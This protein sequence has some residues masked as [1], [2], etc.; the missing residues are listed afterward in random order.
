MKH[1]IGIDL[2]TTNSV[3]ATFDGQDP[4]IWKSPEQ[5]DITPSAIFIDR[6][7]RRYIGQ[8][9]YDAAPRDPENSALLF[10]RLMGTST[11]IRLAAAGL[12]LTPQEC[13]AEILKA[14]CGYLDEEILPQDRTAAVITVPAAFN[15]MQKNATQKAASLAGIGQAALIQEPVAAVMSVMRSD[16]PEGLFLIYDLGGGTLDIALAEA[17]GGRVNLLA[18]GGL[19]LF[20]GRDFDRILVHSLVRPWLMNNFSLPDDLPASPRYRSLMRLAAWA[21]EKAKTE[22]S[23]REETVISLSENETRTADLDGAEIFLDIPLSRTAF[24][25]LMARQIT[26]SVEAARETLEKAGLSPGDLE[27]IVFIGG[28]TKYKPLRDKVAFELGIRSAAQV[29]PLTAVAEGASIYA[30]S[31]DWTT[32]GRSRKKGP[33]RLASQ[34]SLPLIF[35]YP[36]RTPE[37]RAVISLQADNPPSGAEFQVDSLDTG[38]TS[39]RLPLTGGASVRVNLAKPGENTFKVFAFQASGQAL[40]L[41][42]DRLVITRTAAAVESIPASHSLGIEVLEKHGGRPA[43]AFLVRSGESLPKKGVQIFRAAETLRAGE[44]K[45]LNF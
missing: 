11:P 22:L 41:N 9:A 1:F 30:E 20:G 33:G 14:L 43:L 36:S 16:R 27:R 4:R 17:L 26:E 23:V 39:G 31:I 12:T 25:N 10:K 28:P 19:A 44:A 40:P 37:A 24:D 45:S 15:Q 32:P 13:S 6:R 3:I 34:G 29:N 18:H 42:E 21:A 8:R 38:W 7:G 2:G 5:S 35:N